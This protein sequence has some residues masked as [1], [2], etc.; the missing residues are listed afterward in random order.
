MITAGQKKLIQ[1][2]N[3]SIMLAIPFY[4]NQV[5]DWI[6]EARQIKSL[7]SFVNLSPLPVGFKNLMEKTLISTYGLGYTFKKDFV[8]KQFDEPFFKLDFDQIG[9][10]EAVR[11]LKNKRI[12]SPESWK[13][14]MAQFSNISWSIQKIERMGALVALRKSL[15]TAIDEGQSLQDWKDGI[16]EVFQE[17]G[18]TPLS[19][20]HIETVFRT[21][22]SS[23]YSQA[24]YDMMTD[25]P[26]TIA[27]EYIAIMD[28]R[29]RDEHAA[30]N[31]FI[32]LKSDPIWDKI[33]PPNGYNCRCDI[34]PLSEY[35]INEKGLG[36]SDKSNDINQAIND[37][38]PEFKSTNRSM[39][40]LEYQLKAL[41]MMK[42]TELRDL[43][44]K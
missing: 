36:I 6:R 35:Y 1:I 23:V 29:V 34:I 24:G 21:N 37:I 20:H 44:R 33:R 16:D 7:N 42:E 3:K 2:E 17:Y 5:T 27:I 14:L 11:L 12:V 38:P 10:D 4:Q 41:E 25:D 19:P 22:L 32:A 28:D 13:Q 18:V 9:F 30:L 8:Q 15:L 39:R 31:G 40:D 43:Q 26:N